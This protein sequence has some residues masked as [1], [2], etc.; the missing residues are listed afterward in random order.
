MATTK[1]PDPT[2]TPA[3]AAAAV[4]DVRRMLG[5]IRD[6]EQALR[7]RHT[8]LTRERMST[9]SANRAREE[10]LADVDRLVAEQGEAW[11]G[12]RARNIAELVSGELR[13]V[14]SGRSELRRQRPALPDFG[15]LS[16]PALCALSPDSVRQSLRAA[17][18]ALP[19][20]DFGLAVD[21]RVKRLAELGAELAAVAADHEALVVAAREA[22]LELRHLDVTEARLLA[23][24]R[25]AEREEELRRQREFTRRVEAGEDR[26]KVER[27]L[28]PPAPLT[29]HVVPARPR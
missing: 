2:A 4:H 28:F 1:K 10:V 24:R 18:E 27:D 29:S 3:A 25:A 26:V 12:A 9:E 11:L 15:A 13:L 6:Q 23:E 7:A 8:A 21:A 17:L 14:P 16:L 22:G 20:A 19:A 5:E